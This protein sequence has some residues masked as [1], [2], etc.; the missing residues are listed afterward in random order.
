MLLKFLSSEAV[1]DIKA[2]FES[3][4]DKIISEDRTW[5]NE[6]LGKENRVIETDIEVEDLHLKCEGDY[7]ETD[8]TN[9][10]EVFSKMKDIPIKV[11]ADERLWAWFALV[12][13]WDYTL[14]RRKDEWK[15]DVDSNAKQKDNKIFNSFLFLYNMSRSQVVNSMS[16]LWWASYYTFDDNRNDK[17]EL[18]KFYYRKAFPSKAVLVESSKITANNDV[19]LGLL[20][21]IQDWCICNKCE[22]KREHIVSTT[23]YL[24]FIGGVSVLD[25]YSRSDIYNLTYQYLD[26]VFLNKVR[27]HI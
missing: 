27:Q 14:Y 25:V 15:L 6:Y 26:K 13:C 22:F 9:T 1:T 5:I 4:K 19:R 8:L 18:T 20:S 17:F 16:R 12:Y 11:A 23:S 2:N 24:N 3:Y 10:M 7:S 21:A